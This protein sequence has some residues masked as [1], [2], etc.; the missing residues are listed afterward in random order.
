M[1]AARLGHQKNSDCRLNGHNQLPAPIFG[2]NFVDGID[3]VSQ[4]PHAG[5]F[6]TEFSL[7]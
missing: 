4:W 7:L 6:R 3:A 5:K 2:V 1:E